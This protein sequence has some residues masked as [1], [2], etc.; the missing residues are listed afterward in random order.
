MGSMPMDM[1]DLFLF[2]I[3]VV[4]FCFAIAVGLAA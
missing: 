2:E 4:A 3:D 1:L